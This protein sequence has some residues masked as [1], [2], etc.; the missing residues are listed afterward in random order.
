MRNQKCYTMSG[1]HYEEKKKDRNKKRGLNKTDKHYSDIY[2][3]LYIY[4]LYRT[5]ITSYAS[6][7]RIQSTA[8]IASYASSAVRKLASKL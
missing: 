8:G 5:S 2:I 4:P 1:L 3:C 7:S 6:V